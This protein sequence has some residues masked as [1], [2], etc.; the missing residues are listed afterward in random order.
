M[1][2]YQ[3]DAVGDK[4]IQEQ[5]EIRR[6]IRGMPDIYIG[7]IQQ[8]PKSVATKLLVQHRCFNTVGPLGMVFL[9]DEV[10]VI[11]Y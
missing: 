10:L 1:R 3:M 11:E 6:L 8:R 9:L 2:W 7:T 4:P 5:H